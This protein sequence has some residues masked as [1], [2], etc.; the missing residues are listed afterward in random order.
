MYYG[1]IIYF[2]ICCVL[3]L[4]QSHDAS[5]FPVPCSSLS[6]NVICYCNAD[7]LAVSLWSNI[8]NWIVLLIQN[9]DP[10]T[11]DDVIASLFL[12]ANDIL[13]YS[14]LSPNLVLV[15]AH[16]DNFCYDMPSA[17]VV[18]TALHY[19]SLLC[20]EMQFSPER[21]STE[22]CLHRIRWSSR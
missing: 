10:K 1:R 2:T 8:V 11:T 17:F 13:T 7:D 14:H 9:G 12:T 15:S 19:K 16:Y 21:L 6:H 18:T 5:L 20:N 4:S 22:H 3:T